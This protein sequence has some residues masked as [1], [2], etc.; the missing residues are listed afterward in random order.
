MNIA[1]CTS[2]ALRQNAQQQ[3]A[4]DDKVIAGIMEWA[5][6][7]HAQR[8]T[9][10][11]LVAGVSTVQELAHGDAGPL[12]ELVLKANETQSRGKRVFTEKP[13]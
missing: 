13:M 9:G 3:T 4:Y 12:R 1:L 2:Q 6:A 7:G 8:L 10:P 5:A 11:K